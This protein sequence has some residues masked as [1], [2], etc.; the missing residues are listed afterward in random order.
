MNG[1][2]TT[3]ARVRRGGFTLIEV[4]VA[5]AIGLCVLTGMMTA[6]IWSSKQMTY[7]QRVSWSHMEILKSSRILTDHIRNASAISAIDTNA[8]AWVELQM[9]N[10]TLSRLVYVN[11]V[12][13][14]RDGYMYVSNSQGRVTIV[15]R[16]MTE[17]MDDG[18][19]P[20]VFRKVGN[21]ALRISYR[22]VEPVPASPGAIQDGMYGAIVDTTIVMRNMPR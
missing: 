21:N 19:S 4:M 18:F 6:F 14:Q 17:I 3:T 20:P 2:A 13:Q 15:T 16:G 1:P 9:P 8:N 5:S 22:L 10:G 12:A 11:P 7:A